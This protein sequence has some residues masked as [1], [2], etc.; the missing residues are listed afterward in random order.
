MEQLETKKKVIPFFYFPGDQDKVIPAKQ[1]IPSIGC[2]EN[3]NE[4][5]GKLTSICS[6]GEESLD[7]T[8]FITNLSSP[9]KN[10][11]V[12][13]SGN[14]KMENVKEFYSEILQTILFPGET[15]KTWLKNNY[16]RENYP[17]KWIKDDEYL[18]FIVQYNY[19]N[20][21]TSKA[22]FSV[23][24]ELINQLKNRLSIVWLADEEDPEM[25]SDG[26][27]FANMLTPFEIIVK[28]VKMKKEE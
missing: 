25:I 17:S 19:F 6:D 11:F 20:S 22:I 24:N 1:S 28:E 13:L 27:E 5:L 21:G 12:M 16:Y 9:N 15:E 2:F 18:V 26:K 7:V 3:V 4:L 14:S 8:S 23:L 10:K